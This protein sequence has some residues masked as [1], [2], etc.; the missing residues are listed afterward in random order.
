MP[1]AT[2]SPLSAAASPLLGKDSR[3]YS[4][5]LL[6]SGTAASGGQLHGCMRRKTADEQQPDLE[7]RWLCHPPRL[8][9]PLPDCLVACAGS[10]A[11]P[12]WCPPTWTAAWL[13]V[14]TQRGRCGSA[15][16]HALE[17]TKQQGEQQLVVDA[18]THAIKPSAT[19]LE[20][21]LQLHSVPSPLQTCSPPAMPCSL[22]LLPACLQTTA[23]TPWAWAAPPSSWPGTCTPRSSTAA[24]P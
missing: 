8:I 19:A 23:S 2:P 21:R 9:A 16:M 24:W 10:P 1:G 6:D 12:R 3:C 14:R 15:G 22:P 18:P 7:A 17:H 13:A 20:P 11:T 4:C 5:C